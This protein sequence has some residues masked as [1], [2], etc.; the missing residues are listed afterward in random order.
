M[1]GRRTRSTDRAAYQALVASFA[2]RPIHE[3]KQLTETM[4]RIDELLTKSRRTAAEDDYL[5]LLSDVVEDWESRH[6]VIPEVHG[7]ELVKAILDE[8]SLRQHDLVGIFG[9]DSIVSE[10]LSGKR[11]LQR[12]HIEQLARFFK[13]SPA[14]FFPPIET[15]RRR[16]LAG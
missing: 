9:T 6:V 10:V 8:R 5:V 1:S 3:E 2:P 13:V 14:A 11:E 7:V 16:K 4:A 15:V 12:K